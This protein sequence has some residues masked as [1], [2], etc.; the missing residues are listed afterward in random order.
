MPWETPFGT[1]LIWRSV[2]KALEQLRPSDKN[3]CAHKDVEY[4][5]HKF[6]FSTPYRSRVCGSKTRVTERAYFPEAICNDVI[7]SC[8]ANKIVRASMHFRSAGGTTGALVTDTVGAPP[9]R[10]LPHVYLTWLMV[11][12]LS[13]FLNFS[14]R[15]CFVYARTNGKGLGTRLTRA[16]AQERPTWRFVT[17][18]EITWPSVLKVVRW[19]PDQPY[20]WV[21]GPGSWLPLSSG[22]CSIYWIWQFAIFY[23]KFEVLW[24]SHVTFA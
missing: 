22:I 6:R 20:L 1:R 11:P 3:S 10:R 19:K 2:A 21:Y 13:R 7:Q 17:F 15:L 16:Y 4:K 23:L 5:V 8:T 18:S 14:S 12:G 24:K 9:P